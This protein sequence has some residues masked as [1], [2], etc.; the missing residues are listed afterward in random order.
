[1]TDNQDRFYITGG[2]LPIG[3]GSYVTREADTQ[4]LEGLRRGEFC[5]VLDTRQMGKSS[6]MLRAARQLQ[7]EG[8]RVAVLDLTAVGQNLT[9]EQWYFGLLARTAASQPRHSEALIAFWKANRDLGP[10]Q[11]FVEGIHQVLLKPSNDGGGEVAPVVLFVDEI[12]AVR[13][14]PFSVDEFFGGIRECYNR[15]SQEAAFEKLTFCLLGVA[16]PTDL[17]RD[18]RLSP[19]NIG[20]RVELQD[21][22]PQEAAPLAQGLEYQAGQT[23]RANRLLQRVLYWTNGHPYMT[24]R[25]CAVVATQGAADAS[26]QSDRARVDACCRD[27]FLTQTARETD[28]NLMFVRNRLLH[29]EADVSTLLHF[30]ATVLRKRV[31]DDK[32][33]PLCSLLRLSGIAAQRGEFLVLRNRVYGTVFDRAWVQSHLPDAEVRRQQAAYNAGMLRTATASGAVFLCVGTLAVVAVFQ[34][35]VARDAQ[36][37]A[38]DQETLVRSQLSRGYVENAVRLMDAG[39]YGAALA[40]LASVIALDRD[41]PDRLVIHWQRFAAAEALAPRVERLWSIGKSV[42]WAACSP[43]KRLVAA[44]GEEGLAHLWDIASGAELP[45]GSSQPVAPGG[46]VTFVGFSPS[47]DRLVACGTGA[48]ARVWDVATRRLLATLPTPPQGADSARGVQASWSNDGRRLALG[49]GERADVWDLSNS[50]PPVPHQVMRDTSSLARLTEAVLSPDGTSLVGLYANFHCATATVPGDT[51]QFSLG[52]TGLGDSFGA[53]HAAWSRDGKRLL[54]AG[55]FGSRGENRGVGVFDGQERGGKG[56]KLVLPFLRHTQQAMWATFSPDET[57]IAS[58]SEDGTVRVWNAQTGQAV[59]PPLRHKLPVT[60]VTFSPS[61]RRVISASSDG[62]ARIWD[63]QTG[64]TLSPPLHHAGAVIVAQFTDENHVL[65]ASRDGTVRV[66]GLPTTTLSLPLVQGRDSF[67]QTG[68]QDGSRLLELTA[69]RMHGYD[70][71]S[72]KPLFPDADN[73]PAHSRAWYGSEGRYVLLHGNHG[74]PAALSDNLRDVQ[75]WSAQTGKP[76]SPVLQA[77]WAILSHDSTKI[78]LCDKSGSFRLVDA[79]TGNPLLPPLHGALSGVHDPS[80]SGFSNAFV[81]FTPD[82]RYLLLLPTP[83]APR[84]FDSHTGEAVGL[85]MPH[86]APVYQWAFSADS[87]YLFTL[88]T[89]SDVQVW[90]IPGG[91]AASAPVPSGDRFSAPDPFHSGITFSPN[92]QV[93]LTTGHQCAYQW[94]LTGATLKPESLPLPLTTR[95]VF[96]PDSRYFAALDQTVW[97]WRVGAPSQPVFTNSAYTAKVAEAIFSPDSRRVLAIRDDGTALFWDT[98]TGRALTP[99]LNQ[100]RIVHGAFSPDGRTAATTSSDGLVRLWDAAT[101][102]PVTPSFTFGSD[103]QALKW[104]PDGRY[105]LIKNLGNYTIWKV[106]QPL[107]GS[108]EAA[109]ARAHLL[110]GEREDAR[111]GTVP[112]DNAALQAAWKRVGRAGQ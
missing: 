49:R 110:S 39:D 8:C 92:G 77:D 48:V 91:T 89:T 25:L 82:D 32:T 18:T 59:T 10:M 84:L 57:R 97:L 5:Y 62:T 53:N 76:M 74:S 78:L 95:F 65:T 63:A 51:L 73:L 28:D 105:L 21:F 40:P 46:V 90:N 94:S 111:L 27:L 3:A 22:T 4:L 31:R 71:T 56:G 43:D 20:R 36:Q 30:Y 68:A 50:P 79:A 47:G 69:H 100:T 72:G 98:A 1:M 55:H 7:E 103:N 70:L 112:V 67:L 37:R 14:L 52:A 86:A 60:Q 83:E 23:T 34:A 26:R 85:P 75:L 61:G 107:Q 17:V 106:P 15:R 11:R 35:R 81:P 108:L 6:L 38:T 102:E 44:G 2:T 93:A 24:Q 29:S 42:H 9:V 87:Q 80:E 66:W 45:L 96:S 88:T 109:T 33:N 101:G 99:P 13:S 12:D 64:K 19:F 58:A 16:A 54:V 104:T 41:N